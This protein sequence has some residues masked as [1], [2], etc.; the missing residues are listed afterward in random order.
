MSS[1]KVCTEC[2]LPETFPRIQFDEEGRCNYCRSFKGIANLS[3][4]KESY[5]KKFEALVKEHR[6]RGAYD[7]LMCYSGGKDSTYTLMLLKKEYGLNILAVTL[8]NGFVSERAVK[9]IGAVVDSLAVDHLFFKPSFDSLRKVFRECAARDIYP[10]K[11]LER[12]STICTSCMAVVKYSALRLAAEKDIPLLAF[13]WSPGQAPLAS[14]ILKNNPQMLRVMQKALFE[15][16][17]K[18]VGGGIRPYFLEEE[19]FS[20]DYR[21]PYNIH[22]LAF[23]EYSEEGIYNSISRLGWEP[24]R[25]VDANSTNCLLNSFAN[26]VH[27]DRF[28]FH[29]YAFEMANLVRQG[30]IDRAVALDKLNQQEVQSL[31]RDAKIELLIGDGQ[32]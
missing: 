28:G 20:G 12:A 5:R 25:D 17:H 29:P 11:T 15:P 24:P 14:S 2:V 32:G 6:G 7:V 22:P 31:E 30:H 8:D 3:S 16:L 9:N 23:L 18:I 1:L 19:H 26:M 4:Q 10:P 27:K 13:G 21:F